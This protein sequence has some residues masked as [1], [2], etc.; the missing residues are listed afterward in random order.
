[1]YRKDGMKLIGAKLREFKGTLNRDVNNL[2]RM[3]KKGTE[4][5]TI[6]FVREQ[7][8]QIVC[9]GWTMIDGYN[10]VVCCNLRDLDAV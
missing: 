4:V 7:E 5:D 10:R 1:M 8:G 2:S 6:T 9:Q 3:V